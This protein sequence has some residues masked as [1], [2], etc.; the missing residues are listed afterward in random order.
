MTINERNAEAAYL[1]LLITERNKKALAANPGAILEIVPLQETRIYSYIEKRFDATT[2]TL[3]FGAANWLFYNEE[4]PRWGEVLYL[5]CQLYANFKLSVVYW[6]P[7][8]VSNPELPR[9]NPKRQLMDFRDFYDKE[10]RQFLEQ[11]KPAARNR[12]IICHM[13]LGGTYVRDVVITNKKNSW[14]KLGDTNAYAIAAAYRPGQGSSPNP[15]LS[16]LHLG[17]TETFDNDSGSVSAWM[18]RTVLQVE[19]EDQLGNAWVRRDILNVKL[20]PFSKKTKAYDLDGHWPLAGSSKWNHLTAIEG[21]TY[22]IW[23]IPGSSPGEIDVYT[24]TGGEIR[25]YSEK[26]DGEHVKLTRQ[27]PVAGGYKVGAVR[28]ARPKTR[29][30][31]F[32]PF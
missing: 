2:F 10:M 23:A 24:A 11:I 5:V 30:Y 7:I 28:A 14:T 4:L 16:I 12:G 32:S 22:D 17:G 27:N 1:A 6:L 9:D 29:L 18:Y 20:H 26:E 8:V 25:R 19:Q 3:I 13:G 31:A 15:S 21:E